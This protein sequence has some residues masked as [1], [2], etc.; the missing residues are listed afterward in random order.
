MKSKK[1][2]LILGLV[3]IGLA[4]YLGVRK[5]DRTHYELP[6]L[7]PVKEAD[8]TTL[9]LTKGKDTIELT[10]DDDRWLIQPEKFTAD[11][12]KIDAMLKTI[13]N[14]SITALASESGSEGRYELDPEKR[15]AVVA[16]KDGKTVRAF[17][18][19]KPAPSGRH[20]FVKLPNDKRVYHAGENFRNAFDQTRDQLRDKVVLAV[21]RDQVKGIDITD[22]AGKALLRLKLEPE[23]QVPDK[24]PATDAKTGKPAEAAPP[25]M[26]WKDG[27]GKPA[28]D[29]DINNLFNNLSRLQCQSFINGKTKADFKDPLYTVTLTGAKTMSL[30]IYDKLGKEED[31]Y[32]AVSSESEYPFLLPAY[33]LDSMV[34]KEEPAPTPAPASAKPAPVKPKKKH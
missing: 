6:V 11:K 31:A 27:D 25:K 20:T 19:G 32:P 1:E 2:F 14:L 17:D 10:K 12:T 18:I 26:V 13:Q 8:I 33:K 22:K 5:T 30:S 21:N 34:K 16:E 15:I 9:K 24:Q 7:T 28:N 3:I 4:A 23:T 29:A